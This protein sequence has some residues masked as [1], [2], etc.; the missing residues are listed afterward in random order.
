MYPVR[1]NSSVNIEGPNF[2]GFKGNVVFSLLIE[3]SNWWFWET[4][5]VLCG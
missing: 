5:G 1:L 4:G 3:K 2:W